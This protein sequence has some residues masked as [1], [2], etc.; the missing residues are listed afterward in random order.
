MGG[1]NY[2]TATATADTTVVVEQ[3]RELACY[4][5]KEAGRIMKK[6]N[7]YNQNQNRKLL[8]ES[9]GSLS[10]LSLTDN[11]NNK[12][13][14]KI[15]GIYYYCLFTGIA[16]KCCEYLGDTNMANLVYKS[17]DAMKFK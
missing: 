11:N 16:T 3:I 17:I 1:N 5:L 13:N 15:H 7:Q 10:S 14:S 12:K 8:L 4:I 6:Q 2:S 9:S